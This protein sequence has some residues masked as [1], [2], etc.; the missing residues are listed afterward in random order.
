MDRILLE[1]TGVG[2]RLEGMDSTICTLAAKTKSIHLDI[3]GFQ[4]R[5]TWLQQRVTTME[6]HLNTIS[7]RDQELFYL[8]SKLIDL[9]DRSC[10]DN[11]CFFGFLEQSEG[12]NVQDFLQSILHTITGLTFDPRWNFEGHIV[13]DHKSM[14]ETPGLARS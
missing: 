14:T 13:W 4:A 7:D 8:R 10:R 2:R 3:V 1:I 11:D 6:D 9:E 5:V 12:S